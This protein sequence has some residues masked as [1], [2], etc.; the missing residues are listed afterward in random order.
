M[1]SRDLQQIHDDLTQINRQL[2]RL[3]DL[4]LGAAL[5]QSGQSKMENEGAVLLESAHRLMLRERE[6][7]RPE[8]NL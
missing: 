8:N 5:K 6:A 1:D 3:Y 4:V 7:R 2:A